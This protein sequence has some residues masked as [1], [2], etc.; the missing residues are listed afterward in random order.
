[1]LL[2]VI[3]FTFGGAVGIARQDRFVALGDDPM[4]TA[5]PIHCG[6][7]TREA[8]AAPLHRPLTSKE[9]PNDHE[10]STTNPIVFCRNWK[11]EEAYPQRET[12]VRLLWSFEFLYV[13]FRAHYR[14][15][16]IYPEANARREQLWRGDVAEVFLQTHASALKQYKEFEISPNGNWLDLNIAPE[17]TSNLMCALRTRSAIDEKKHVWMAELAIPMNCLIEA[18]DPNVTW[19]LNLFR[20]EGREPERSY[21]S[22]QPTNTSKPNFHV[23]EAFGKL[24]F[25]RQ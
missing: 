7:V 6:P 24:T 4:M 1:M 8:V 12:E 10:W 22:W 3:V 5:K 18:F 25:L 11:G 15:L 13:R 17:G 20:I 23:P 21:S 16:F 14:D 19:R 2:L 9:F